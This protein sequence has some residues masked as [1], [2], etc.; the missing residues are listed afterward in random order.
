M[1]KFLKEKQGLLLIY[2]DKLKKNLKNSHKIKKNSHKKIEDIFLEDVIST[3]N[4]RSII[5]LCFVYFLQI[6]THQKSENEKK[7]VLVPVAVNIGKKMVNMY[8]NNLKDKYLKK[9][10]KEIEAARVHDIDPAALEF[11]DLIDKHDIIYDKDDYPFD[12]DGDSD[13]ND[14]YDEDD[15]SDDSDENNPDDSDEN[16]PDDNYS[17][18]NEDDSSVDDS[19]DNPDRILE[20]YELPDGII[21]TPGYL[22]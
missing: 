5:N 16:N 7:Y 14:S 11:P 15:N 10:K 6:Y 12:K 19:K 1:Y 8:L 20:D 22:E 17:D 18:N 4:K 21:I 2:I 13:D 3:L 9:I